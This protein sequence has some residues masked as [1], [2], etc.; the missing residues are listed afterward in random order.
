MRGAYWERNCATCTRKRQIFKREGEWRE[1]KKK[2]L[3]VMLAGA[4]VSS[5]VACGGSDGAGTDG[6]AGADGAEECSVRG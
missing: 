6:A 3:S 2:L 4:M 5:L 1:M